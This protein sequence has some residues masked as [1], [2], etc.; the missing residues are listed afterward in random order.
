MVEGDPARGPHSTGPSTLR[1]AQESQ[2]QDRLRRG[3]LR[4]TLLDGRAPS[5]NAKGGTWLVYAS[6][7]KRQPD[8]AHCEGVYVLEYDGWAPAVSEGGPLVIPTLRLRCINMSMVA[9]VTLTPALSRQ[10]PVKGEGVTGIPH[11]RH[12][13]EG[14]NP[15]PAWCAVTTPEAVQ[16]TAR[17]Y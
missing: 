8:A 17:P 3:L 9:A 6:P 5:L 4:T 15:S 14:G 10:G 7:R 2:A 13:R 16:H 12:S 11:L 1:Q